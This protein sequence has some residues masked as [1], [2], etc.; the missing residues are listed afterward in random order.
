MSAVD[1]NLYQSS[2]FSGLTDT[3]IA[4]F[5]KR[6]LSASEKTLVTSLITELESELCRAT[7]RNFKVDSGGAVP[8]PVQYYEYF[9]GGF[10]KI[11]P[12]NTPVDSLVAIEIDG[13]DKTSHYTE[14][15][16]YWIY[17]NFIVFA[18]PV[19]GTSH[20][21]KS[22]KITYTIKKFWGDDVIL[23]LK[24]WVAYEFL[25]SENAG[26]GNSSMSFAEVAQTFDLNNFIKERDKVIFRYTDFEI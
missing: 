2:G 3:D 4:N 14:N 16:N 10:T 22:V 11:M 18:S 15:V 20:N 9:N 1:G 8:V 13:V 21:L 5:L 26:V 19:V 12:Q 25:K 7:N 24:K 23:M 17:D 6:T